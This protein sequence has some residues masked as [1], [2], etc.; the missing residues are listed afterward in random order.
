MA[1]NLPN[2]MKDMNL[3]IQEAQQTRINSTHTKIH[4]NQTG[5]GQR[6]TENLESSKRAVTHQIQEILN[7]LITSFSSK[8]SE[9]RRQWVDI[10]KMLKGKKLSTK[11]SISGQTVLQK[12]GRQFTDHSESVLQTCT[13]LL[14]LPCC[15]PHSAAR[16]W[17]TSASGPGL[18]A[19]P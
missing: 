2:L 16:C 8:T 19:S 18:W 7:K 14:W 3:Q 13:L 4:H 17:W 5:K 12:W 6:Q 1:E 11:N 10:L 9:A 15:L